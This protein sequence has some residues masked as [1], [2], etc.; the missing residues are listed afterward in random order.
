MFDS[1]IIKEWCPH[2][3]NL[4]EMDM[5]TK[6]GKCTL[7]NYKIGDV[8]KFDKEKE[9][10]CFNFNK[11]KKFIWL[12][13]SCETCHCHIDGIAY[14]DIKTNVIKS[15]ELTR[16]HIDINPKIINIEDKYYEW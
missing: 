3:K 10:D 14:I 8:F 1:I 15:I 5:Q 11:T 7:H 4:V 9:S 2:C 12:L 13:G 16:Y 6:K